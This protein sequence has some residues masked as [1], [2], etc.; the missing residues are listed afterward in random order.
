MARSHLKIHSHRFTRESRAASTR[1]GYTDVLISNP[2]VVVSS[3][4]HPGLGREQMQK[5]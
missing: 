1:T 3:R 4:L 2:S 5:S